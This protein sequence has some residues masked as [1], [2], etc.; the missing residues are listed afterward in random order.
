MDPDCFPSSCHEVFVM[1]LYHTTMKQW[2]RNEFESGGTGP[3][4]KWGHQSGANSENIFGR[5]PPL[6]GSKSTISRF[7]EYLRNG[8]YSLFSFLFAVLL[9]VPP[10]SHPFVKCPM[11]SAPLQ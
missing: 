7:G 9:A 10:C 3:A 8:Q 5:A 4:Q 11:E 2:R 1:M 6:F